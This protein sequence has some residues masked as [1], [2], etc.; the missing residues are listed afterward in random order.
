MIDTRVAL[1]IRSAVITQVNQCCIRHDMLII[2]ITFTK[3][4]NKKS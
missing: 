3:K 4:T 1:K 2:L